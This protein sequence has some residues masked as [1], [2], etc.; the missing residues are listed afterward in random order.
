MNLPSAN[1]WDLKEYRQFLSAD[2]EVEIAVCENTEDR[3]EAH[4]AAL[5]AAIGEVAPEALAILS[6]QEIDETAFHGDWYDLADGQ[7]VHDGSVNVMGVDQQRPKFRDIPTKIRHGSSQVPALWKPGGFAYAF[8]NPPYGL[9]LAPG[10]IQDLY[11][12][13][14]A[15]LAPVG[16]VRCL[17]WHSP[18]LLKIAPQLTPGTEWWGVFA[19]TTYNR[20]SRQVFGIAASATD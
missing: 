10:E 13:V 9:R 2:G 4:H 16:R 19:L 8:S 6:P 17:S 5:A 1:L 20:V 7:L 11:R 14:V 18:E 3:P 12:A 15:L